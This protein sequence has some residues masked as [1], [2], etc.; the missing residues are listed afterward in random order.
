MRE[1]LLPYLNRLRGRDACALQTNTE[2]LPP[3]LPEALDRADNAAPGHVEIDSAEWYALYAEPA[4]GF[5]PIGGV[6]TL[7]RLCGGHWFIGSACAHTRLHSCRGP[8]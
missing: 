7:R 1:A 6:A 5:C 2:R 3:H 8:Q 4:H